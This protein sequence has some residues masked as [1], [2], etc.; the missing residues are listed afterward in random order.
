[1]S[2]D[3][4]GVNDSSF[5]SAGSPT[6]LTVPANKGGDYQVTASIGWAYGF[7]GQGFALIYLNGVE[8]TRNLLC[9]G[10]GL[11]PLGGYLQVSA[12]LRLNPGDYLQLHLYQVN[13]FV[14][15]PSTMLAGRTYL[16]AVRC[17]G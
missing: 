2:F 14:G 13:N 16:Q 10:A 7:I 15:A 4:A 5:W 6:R 9:A 1:V 11:S 12:F 3:T 8:I 17:A